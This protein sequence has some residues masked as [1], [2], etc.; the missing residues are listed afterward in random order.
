M[1]QIEWTY[2]SVD[3]EEALDMIFYRPLG[4]RIAMLSVN[5]GIT[6][7]ILTIISI[8]SGVIAGHL[9]YYHDLFINFWGMLFLVFAEMFDSADGQL[10]RITH[11]KSRIGRI[12]DGFAGNIMFLSIYI[13]LCLR[14]MNEGAGVW[15]FVIAIISGLSHS[16]Q[17]AMADYYRNAYMYFGLN[18][19]NNELDYS[20]E[21]T[22]DYNI[23]SW[24]IFIKKLLMWFYVKYTTQ[25]EYFSKN[26]QILQNTTAEVFKEDIPGWFSM[27]YRNL[28]KP[29][30][31]YYNMLTSNTRMIALFT[32]II[33]DRVYLYLIFEILV[34]NGLLFIVTLI[35]E[36]KNASLVKDVVEFSEGVPVC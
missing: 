24:R 26:F 19:D 35:Q 25:Q 29:M 8:L 11:T 28:N 4:Y 2:K 22:H 18:S 21:V 1:S 16:L 31:K 33:L 14:M 20:K 30:L 10:A 34:L 27:K 9:F 13:H 5:T 7:T 32:S 6:P 23:I 36:R 17:C 3:T 15:I 12:L